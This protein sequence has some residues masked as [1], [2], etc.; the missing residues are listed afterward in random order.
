MIIDPKKLHDQ[1]WLERKKDYDSIAGSCRY[2][3]ILDIII[4]G[5][6]ESVLDMGCGSGYLGFLIKKS[7]PQ[8]TVHGFDI[9]DVALVKTEMIDLKYQLDLDKQDIPQTD[10]YYDVAVCS[11]LLEHIY[12]VKHGLEE[13]YR[14]LKRGGLGIIT[15]PNHGFWKFR[16]HSLIGKLPSIIAD[17]RHLHTFNLALLKQKTEEAG[18]KVSKVDGC[19]SRFLILNKISTSLFSDTIILQV[20]KS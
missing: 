9:S 11:E 12:D 3:I 17:E 18:F 7:A 5:K 16:L 20:E 19:R 8:I 6:P 13:M 14:I 2:K 10:G 1:E 4:N 15:V